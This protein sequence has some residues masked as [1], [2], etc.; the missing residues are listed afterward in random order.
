MN[1]TIRLIATDL[2][3]TMLHHD[4]HVT[5]RNYRAVERAVIEG[6]RYVVATGRSRAN[7]PFAALPEMDYL[8]TENGAVVYE[9]GGRQVLYQQVIPDNSVRQAVEIGK[10]YHAFVEILADGVII[11]E[12]AGIEAASRYHLASIQEL[13]LKEIEE[14]AIDSFEEVFGKIPAT[15]INIICG[16]KEDWEGAARELKVLDGFTM[17]SDGYGLE[18]TK[19]GVSK[20]TAMEWLCSYLKLPMSRVM[21]FGDGTNDM[22]LLKM[23]GVG[24]AMDNARENVKDAADYVAAR[25]S[26]DGVAR[27]IEGYLLKRAVS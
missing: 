7:I 5:E 11:V 18:L 17:T 23:A 16:A 9:G 2:D 12:K 21:A 8:I 20:G 26:E 27:F 13:L 25:N 10:K 24:V 6:M 1:R 22:V 15:K 3:G 4:N 14:N 19:K